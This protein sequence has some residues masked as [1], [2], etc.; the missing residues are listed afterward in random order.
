MCTTLLPSYPCATS[1]VMQM[2]NETIIKATMN[3]FIFDYTL[4]FVREKMLSA[5]VG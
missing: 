4:G 3:D 2:A 1:V 5:D